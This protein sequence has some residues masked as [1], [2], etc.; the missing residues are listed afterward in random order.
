MS[1]K[2]NEWF[3]LIRLRNEGKCVNTTGN[4]LADQVLEGQ[5]FEEAEARIDA[6]WEALRRKPVNIILFEVKGVKHAK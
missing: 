5:L 2:L 3:E 1:E 4:V 6:H